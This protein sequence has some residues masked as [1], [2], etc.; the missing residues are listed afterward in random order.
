V[1]V[2]YSK[3][4]VRGKPKLLTRRESQ[5]KF[6]D[7]NALGVQEALKKEIRQALRLSEHTFL[8]RWAVGLS[9]APLPSCMG[10]V[11]SL[12]PKK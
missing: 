10:V 9:W 8:L 4:K 3:S 12:S 6:V 11:H 1:V 5:R 2:K 7:F